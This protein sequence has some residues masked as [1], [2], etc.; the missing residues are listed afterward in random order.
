VPIALLSTAVL[1][2]AL[3]AAVALVAV[4]LLHGWWRLLAVPGA[5][6]VA[7]FAVLPA[8]LAVSL[9]HPPSR[10]VGDERPID[11]GLHAVDTELR[12]DDGARLAA[13]YVPSE[14]GAAVVLL[15]GSGGSR[16]RVLEHA[17]ALAGRGYGVLIPDARGHGDSDGES[18]RLGWFGDTDVRAAVDY[19]ANRSD[20]DDG[21]IAAVGLSMGGEEAIGAAGADSRIRAVVAEGATGRVRAD[22]SW[23]HHGAAERVFTWVTE[24]LTDLLSAASPP[25][26]LADAIATTDAPV[27]LIAGGDVGSEVSAAAHL[28]DLSPETVSVWVASGAGHTEALALDPTTWTNRVDRFLTEA[29][30]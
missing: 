2:V 9:T 6:A 17:A 15:H 1:G 10:H 24:E 27:L 26:P 20:V 11:L 23:R 13:W 3:V 16:S 21:R 19:L 4:R 7:M 30:S 22:E 14:T 8:V 12:T 29:L 18:N 28:A 25:T 5:A